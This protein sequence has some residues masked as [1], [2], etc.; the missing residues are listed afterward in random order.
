MVDARYMELL[1]RTAL[2]ADIEGMEGNT[3]GGAKG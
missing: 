2:D 3:R 1:F